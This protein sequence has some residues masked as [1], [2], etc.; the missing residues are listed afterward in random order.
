MKIFI[1]YEYNKILL[2]SELITKNYQ[3]INSIIND[4]LTVN[5]IS[6][7]IQSFFLDYIKSIYKIYI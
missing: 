3:S 7:D 5:N 2:N 6:E 4:F 1:N